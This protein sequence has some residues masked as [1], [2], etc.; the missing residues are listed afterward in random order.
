L[1]GIYKKQGDA[2]NEREILKKAIANCSK[3]DEFKKR[4]DEIDQIMPES[5]KK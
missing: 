1:A 5:S 4:L 3:N 2:E